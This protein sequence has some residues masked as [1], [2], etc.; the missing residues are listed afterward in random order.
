M[1]FDEPVEFTFFN[2]VSP[3]YLLCFSFKNFIE[4]KVLRGQD[5]IDSLVDKLCSDWILLRFDRSV[6]SES[7]LDCSEIFYE[8]LHVVG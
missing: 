3:L 1:G 7:N 5:G 8:R 4:E 2:L 6:K